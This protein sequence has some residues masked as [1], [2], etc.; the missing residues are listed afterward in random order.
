L[1]TK[2]FLVFSFVIFLNPKTSFDSILFSGNYSHFQA[3]QNS[4]ERVL[5]LFLEILSLSITKPPFIYTC[6][7]FNNHVLPIWFSIS[8]FVAMAH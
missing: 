5:N 6:E 7:I 3:E 1:L 8:Y 2:I 4:W